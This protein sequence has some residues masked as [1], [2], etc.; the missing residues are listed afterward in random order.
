MNKIYHEPKINSIIGISPTF[1]LSEEDL[2]R[3]GE[4]FLTEQTLRLAGVRRVSNDVGHQILSKDTRQKDVEYAGLGIPCFQ[5]LDGDCKVSHWTI[6][7]D[8]PDYEK[9]GAGE[10]KE[11]RKYIK[12]PTVKNQLYIPPMLP[13]E[14]LQRTDL[15]IVICEGEFK[16]MALARA[17]TNDFTSEKWSFVPLGLSGVD[18]FKKKDTSD[19]PHG[20]RTITEELTDF[21]KIN[22]DRANVCICFDSDLSDKPAVKAARSRLSRFI[23]EKGAKVFHINF[24]KV[25]QGSSTKGIDDYLGAIEKAHGLERAIGTFLEMLEKAQLP[26]KPKLLT[27]ENFELVEYG[28]AERAA[29]VYYSNTETGES[30]RVCSPL[31]IV[32]ETQTE[33]GENYG[34]LLEWRDSQNRPHRW[35]MP[36]EF[37]HSTGSKL[38]EYLAAS[39]LEIMPSRKHHEKLAFYIATAQV[40]KTFISTDKIGLH[41]ECFVLPDKTF[42]SSENQ[43][44]YQTDYDGHHNFKTAGTLEDWQSNISKY[45]PNNSRLLLAVSA[46]FAAPLLPI[47]HMQGGGF[48]FRGATSNGKTTALYAGGS[49]C[50]GDGSEH[51]FLLPWKATLNGLEIVAAGHNH[52]L[53]CLDEI[54]ECESREIGNAAYM[55]ANG[56]GKIRMTKTIAVRHS[57]SWNLMVL[58]NGEHKLSD[59]ISESG[60]TVKGGQEIRLCDIEADTGGSDYSRTYTVSQTVRRS[61]IIYARHRVFITAHRSEPTCS[62]WLNRAWTKFVQPGTTSKN[63]LSIRL[64]RTA[65]KFRQRFCE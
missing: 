9:N 8:I 28:E 43:I 58:S 26:K 49:V 21:Q 60:G 27:A 20:Q 47:V 30:F 12:P 10:L 17:A 5:H 46:A 3:R 37:L 62:G 54:G 65:R 1:N 19:T 57:L 50:G 38:A 53:L 24:P 35:A 6:R 42:G 14:L 41:G 7:R 23:K 33:R 52:N 63:R 59:K 25:Y 29:G 32:A 4:S 18:N 44:V 55:P 34:R 64:Y 56:R 2:K 61:P 15:P 13:T 36:I 40:D 16:A 45:C 31:K 51:G 22:F 11:K 48:H 39:G